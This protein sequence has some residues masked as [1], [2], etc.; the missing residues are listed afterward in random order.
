MGLAD[1]LLRTPAA[2][3]VVVPVDGPE[4]TIRDLRIAFD[5][6]RTADQQPNTG[7]VRIYNLSER[8]RALIS[9]SIRRPPLDLLA[10]TAGALASPYATGVEQ[11]DLPPVLARRYQY[12]S[13]RIRAGFG[14]LLRE[15]FAGTS[16]RNSSRPAGVD[17][18][19]TI[20]CSDGGA[21][22]NH[23]AANRTFERG[24]PVF[25][26]VQHLVKVLGLRSGNVD[27]A[28]WS[29]LDV[30]EGGGPL[31]GAQYFGAPYTPA[32]DPA[33]QLTQLLEVY[34]IRWIVDDGA[35]YLLGPGGY[36]PGAPIELGTPSNWPEETEEGLLVTVPCNPL[37]RPGMRARL[38]SRVVDGVFFV[39]SVR[40]FGDTHA[41][42]WTT[43]EVTT[44][45]GIPGVF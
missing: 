41:T 21:L 35:V 42:I 5:V 25:A 11:T 43:V 17:W 8:T 18:I 26:A 7:Q 24:D 14:R 12:A 13:V 16:D 40:H 1:P 19:T 27:A 4:I 39:Q 36:L 45:A 10:A 33:A 3:V 37:I 38:R 32:G 15:V 9:G 31:S 28:T 20:E 23:A 22:M 30:F 6:T 34:R 29:A 44:L 2:D